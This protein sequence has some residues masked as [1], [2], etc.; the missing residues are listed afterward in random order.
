MEHN[1]FDIPGQVSRS[2]PPLPPEAPRGNKFFG[3]LRGFFIFIALVLVVLASF[4]I[5]FQLGKK[6]LSPAKKFA[7]EKIKAEIPEPPPSIKSLQKLG[8]TVS[9]EAK[10]HLER[11]L[12]KVARAKPE[13]IRERKRTRIVKPAVAGKQYYYKIQAG[14]F[15]DRSEAQELAEKMKAAGI[16]VFVRKVKAGWR[17]Q[18]GAYNTR[19][20]AAKMQSGLK[21]KGF[22]ATIIHEWN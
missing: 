8:I 10:K 14:V 4:W 2:E 22:D 16:S 12:G 11:A 5:S 19:A 17:V 13:S 9:G 21:Q 18:A 6:I 20:A 15:A 1:P 7:E 3:W